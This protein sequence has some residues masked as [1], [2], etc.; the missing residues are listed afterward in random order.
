MITTNQ[1]A[2]FDTREGSWNEI[3]ER[4]GWL[5]LKMMNRWL[6]NM[7]RV[8]VWDC[9]TGGVEVQECD[10]TVKSRDPKKERKPGKQ[11]PAERKR[12]SHTST[13]KHDTRGRRLTSVEGKSTEKGGFWWRENVGRRQG[14][15]EENRECVS[16]G[17]SG[18]HKH[19]RNNAGE[20]LWT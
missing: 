14:Q 19:Y 11:H 5:M 16:S 9:V 15:E 20:R 4:S 6:E 2:W 10:G 13:H 1:K 7:G 12:A 17:W 3:C 18:A 8:R